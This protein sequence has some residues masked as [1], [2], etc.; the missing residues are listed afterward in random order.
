V[1]FLIGWDALSR[2]AEFKGGSVPSNYHC[3]L[4][5]AR[6]LMLGDAMSLLRLTLEFVSWYR[7]IGAGVGRVPNRV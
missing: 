4:A 7:V 5:S 2:D 6:G 1:C 3:G